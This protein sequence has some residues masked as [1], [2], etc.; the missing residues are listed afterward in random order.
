MESVEKTLHLFSFK[1]QVKVK[2][3]DRNKS[4]YCHNRF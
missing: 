2:F 3:W 1:W 4:N